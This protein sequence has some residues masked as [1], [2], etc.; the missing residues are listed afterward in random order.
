MGVFTN[1][2]KW[3]MAPS[4]APPVQPGRQ[5]G[6]PGLDVREAYRLWAPTYAAETAISALDDELAATMLIGLPR[7]HIL[8]AG[9]GIGR[10]IKNIP[11]AVGIDLSPEMLAAGGAINVVA[12][13]V[14]SMPFASGRFDMVWCRLV[15]GH[16]PDPIR[17]YRELARVCAPGGH[18]FVTDFH[19]QAAAAGHRRTLTDP[20]GVV[21][22]IE[23]HVHSNHVELAASAG[24]K[25]IDHR[26]GAV[27]PSIRGIYRRGLGLRAYFRDCGLR[28]VAAYLFHKPSVPAAGLYPP[29]AA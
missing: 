1:L 2:L 10:R 5:H 25:L 4:G 11:G 21:H 12:G 8:D 19:P 20:A 22:A 3:S 15:L 7:A 14:R 26:D 27:G 16:L 24:L 18:L 17:A 29:P 6:L 13:D 23:H 9:C 28:L